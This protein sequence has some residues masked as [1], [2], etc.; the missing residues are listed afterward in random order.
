MQIHHWLKYYVSMKLKDRT[1]DR[2][3]M[4]VIPTML[5][6]LASSVWHGFE[7]GFYLCFVTFGFLDIFFR[8]LAS[9]K[10]A[11]FVESIV[12]KVILKVL[13]TCCALFCMNYSVLGFILL[14]WDRVIPAWAAFGYCVHYMIL[15]G[16]PL[17]LLLPKRQ[18]TKKVDDNKQLKTE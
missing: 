7:V 2:K 15:I 3:K 17:A 6:Y 11:E 10:V 9:T 5:T 18:R 8:L 1:V 16:L 12:P 13:V 4:Q 14:K